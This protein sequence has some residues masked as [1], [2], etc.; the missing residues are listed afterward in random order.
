MSSNAFIIVTARNEAD[1]LGATLQALAGAFPGAP[2]WVADDGSSDGTS[3]VAHAAGA[4]VLRSARS[5]GKGTAATQAAHAALVS[6]RPRGDAIV[7][8]CDGDLGACAGRLKELLEPLRRGEAEMAVAS[9]SERRGGGFGLAV[10]FARWAIRKRCGLQAQAPI[11]GQRALRVRALEDVLPFAAGFG[12][13]IG[14]T[15][16][17]VRAGHRIREVALDL[18]HRS[19]GRTLAGFAHRGRQLVDFVR[20]YLARRGQNGLRNDPGSVINELP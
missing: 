15:V 12:M 9:F 19:S 6:L 5:L 13:E 1:R 4:T 14:M 2:T 8:L 18:E 20:V 10:A 17:A 7:L 16:D 11:C 3:Q